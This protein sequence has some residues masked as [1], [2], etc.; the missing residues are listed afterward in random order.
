MNDEG[1]EEEERGHVHGPECLGP[2][3]A[4]IAGGAAF[5]DEMA[6]Q[7]MELTDFANRVREMLAD[8]LA[9]EHLELVAALFQMLGRVPEPAQMA[10]YW[11]GMAS[12]ALHMRA[13]E[14]GHS[15][16]CAA[17]GCKAR[18]TSRATAVTA[19]WLPRKSD[20]ALLCPACAE[21]ARGET[22]REWDCIACGLNWRQSD[23]SLSP[24]RFS[25]PRTDDAA[26]RWIAAE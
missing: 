3:G 4:L 7:R 16:I 19:D 8:G 20:G 12:M 13:P 10:N 22:S 24:P 6:R 14:T 15:I 26:H 2:I 23:A 25:C 1:E 17:F 9:Q 21:K 18:A 5:E 11:E